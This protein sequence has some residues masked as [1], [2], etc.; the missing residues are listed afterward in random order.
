M[1]LMTRKPQEPRR[2][3][4]TMTSPLTRRERRLHPARKKMMTRMTMRREEVVTMP[5]RI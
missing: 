3:M 2:R 4:T 1:M 5:L